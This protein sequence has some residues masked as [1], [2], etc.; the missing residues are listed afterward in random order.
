MENRIEEMTAPTLEQK[1]RKYDDSV[2][3]NRVEAAVEKLRKLNDSII[4]NRVEAIVGKKVGPYKAM[5]KEHTEFIDHLSKGLATFSDEAADKAEQ[6]MQ[7]LAEL[8]AAAPEGA[9]PLQGEVEAGESH[10][11]E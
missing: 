6:L 5:I 2:L 1:K 9:V 11:T 7:R 8:D 4:K 3:E 10:Q